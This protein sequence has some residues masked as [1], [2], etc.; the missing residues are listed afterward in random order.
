MSCTKF[1][2]KRR[3]LL[4]ATG[5]NTST[6]SSLCMLK[7]NRT[8]SSSLP[9]MFYF[10]NSIRLLSSHMWCCLLSRTNQCRRKHL[11]QLWQCMMWME[12]RVQIWARSLRALLGNSLS[13]QAH[14]SIETTLR[15]LF[16][17]PSL[18]PQPIVLLHPVIK[19]VII[20]QNQE[21]LL[22]FLSV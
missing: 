18:P 13:N 8:A 3:D 14:L 4:V 6:L 11:H 12:L 16:K 7:I 19:T 21:R 10:H 9:T 22:M 2:K 15:G 5:A 17:L 20:Q 1:Q